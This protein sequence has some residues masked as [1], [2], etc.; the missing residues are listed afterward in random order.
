MV[1]EYKIVSRFGFNSIYHIKN[2]VI[3]ANYKDLNTAENHL[4][5]LN[6]KEVL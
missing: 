3:I 1:N 5:S 2:N 4:D 6:K